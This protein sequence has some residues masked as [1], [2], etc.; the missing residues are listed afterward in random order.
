[1]VS[2]TVVDVF[3]QMDNFDFQF[4]TVPSASITLSFQERISLGEGTTTTIPF[5]FSV[6]GQALSDIPFTLR[7]LTYQQFQDITTTSV[8]SVFP[9]GV[10]PPAAS[11]SEGENA[12]I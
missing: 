11:E 10:V 8:N 9:G 5:L 4:S 6:I 3:G 2:V 1:M 7:S 12:I